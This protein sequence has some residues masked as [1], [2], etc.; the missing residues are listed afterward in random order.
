MIE[1]LNGIQTDKKEATI[2]LEEIYLISLKVEL[3]VFQ[4]QHIDSHLLVQEYQA[5]LEKYAEMVEQTIDLNELDNHNYVVKP[6]YD[7]GLQ[8]LAAKLMKVRLSAAANTR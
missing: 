6:E 7:P 4:K 8:A 5:N 1:A 2:L 3:D